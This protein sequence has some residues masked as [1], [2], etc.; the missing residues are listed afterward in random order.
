LDYAAGMVN[1]IELIRSQLLKLTTAAAPVKS[2]AETLDRKLIEIEDELIQRKLT[3][4]GQ[5]T[6][7]WPPKL[8]SKLGYLASGLASS[9][10]G[11]TAQQRQVHSQFKG[12]I[13]RLRQRLAEVLSKDLTAF[14][15]LLVDNN[16]E[17]RIKRTP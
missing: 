6:V 4:Q 5:D 13:A 14:D 1:Q 8:L 12:Q 3:G 7:R 17:T 16:V 2:A 9:D 10:Y 15:K 11:P